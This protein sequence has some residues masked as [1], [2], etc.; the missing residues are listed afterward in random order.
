MTFQAPRRE[1]E[2]SNTRRCSRRC[3][4]ERENW[5]SRGIDVNYRGL[6]NT[7]YLVA[8]SNGFRVASGR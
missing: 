2:L 7:I 4:V 5:E 6:K 1:N 3:K 8:R